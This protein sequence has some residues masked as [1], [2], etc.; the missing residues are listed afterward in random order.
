MDGDETANEEPRNEQQVAPVPP[1]PAEGFDE[2]FV[3]R[4]LTLCSFTPAA[5]EQ[6]GQCPY[7][8]RGHRYDAE[9]P[10]PSD[11]VQ[12]HL[13]DRDGQEHPHRGPCGYH[14]QHRRTPL[15]GDQPAHRSHHQRQGHPAEPDAA[16]E[17]Q[18]E[19]QTGRGGEASHAQ[20]GDPVYD[21]RSQKHPPGVEAV[22][23]VAADRQTH[24]QAENGH[25]QAVR[26]PSRSQL[27]GHGSQEDTKGLAGA[28]HQKGDGGPSQNDAPGNRDLGGER[29]GGE[30]LWALRQSVS[31]EG[32]VL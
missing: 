23:Q 15:C 8:H 30:R 11:R 14:S 29:G 27:L 9:A 6:E 2:G 20:H 26:L 1:G 28:H 21:R 10:S 7:Q 19:Q 25:R 13:G 32:V 4:V 18:K 31:G 22:G 5:R 24:Q 3:D 17:S 12:A 16:Q